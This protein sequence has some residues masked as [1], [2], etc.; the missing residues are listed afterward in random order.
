[1]KMSERLKVWW[2]RHWGLIKVRA[3]YKRKFERDDRKNYS[4]NAQ[5]LA[6]V[7]RRRRQFIFGG[8]LAAGL[9]GAALSAS[10]AAADTLFTNFAFPASGAP[11]NRTM[12]AR[13]SDIYNLKDY[14]A[15]GNGSADDTN[16]V[17]A[18][19]LA[20]TNNATKGGTAYAPP[21]TYKV[22]E[23]INIANTSVAPNYTN[24]RVI[25]AAKWSTYFTGNLPNGFVFYQDDNTN[26]PEEVSHLSLVNSSTWIAS[27]ALRLTNSGCVFNQV[28]FQGMICVLLP[29]NIYDAVFDA[30]SGEA[31][32]DVTT[33]YNGSLGIAGYAPHIR[34]WRSTSPFMAC[35]QL[36]G[37]NSSDICGNGIENCVVA[38]D[39]GRFTGWASSCTVSGTVLTVGGTLGSP[40]DFPQFQITHQL[41][42]RGL[43]LQTW[44][45]MPTAGGGVTITGDGI[46]TITDATTT[47]SSTT[48]TVNGVSSPGHGLKVGAVVEG[49][50]VTA[51]TTITALGSGTGGAG[52]YT[53]SASQT[54]SATTIT[55]TDAVSGVKLTG[56]NFA[57][58]Y[59]ISASFT[60]STPIPIFSRN[61]SSI[62]AVTIH[63]LQTEACYCICFVG[64]C[65]GTTIISAG[66]GSTPL[67]CVDQFGVRA[68]DPF[69]GFYI[70]TAGATSLIS[71]VPANNPYGGTF[72]F[73]P[74]A[75]LVGV[76]LDSCVGQKLSDIT[77]TGIISNGSGGAGTIL[78][79]TVS[80]G[81]A[82]AIGQSVT[83]SGVTANTA[84][85]GNFYTD[86]TLTGTG[87][88]GTYRVN[89]SQN[90]SSTTL[91]L[92]T[93]ADYV[94]PTATAS[95][96]G[97]RF[98]NCQ[99]TLPAGVTTGLSTLN[100]TFT[101]L[102]GQAG[103]NNNVNLYQ[104]MSYFIIDAAKSGGGTAAPGDIVQA[105]G[106]QHIQV[107][108]DITN[109]R[110]GGGG[111]I[112]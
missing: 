63:S 77:S 46:P 24:G 56:Q 9:S 70:Q 75:T 111:N 64:S 58:T 94:M 62:S 79:I 5:V 31:N 55:A 51:G 27:G 61:F 106:S 12:P 47:I 103:S 30:C 18:W 96:A 91:T 88:S 4:H 53:V 54:V 72:Y 66:G 65:S 74:N 32:V 11:T 85:T 104:G 44:G 33:G 110:Y 29:S 26:G 73:D 60:I 13:L 45:T 108:Y 35:F 112:S 19:Y 102:P 78:N 1:M 95:K 83:G 89:N 6:R 52:T 40:V 10:P 17:K 36:W 2:R 90:V 101:C 39:L 7:E 34:G 81:S 42:G 49:T 28:H 93:G 69:C 38:I 92:H 71:C 107:Y 82:V 15:V 3:H 98:V 48:M 41:W 8:A 86:P 59:K 57:G 67:E 22:T 21:G 76:T 80:A 100:M 84:V 14:G 68:Y 99:S 23:E 25:G 20:A 109:W 43:T 16:A 50:G 97:L 37:A 87:G 105:G